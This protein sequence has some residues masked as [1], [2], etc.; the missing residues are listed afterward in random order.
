MSRIGDWRLEVSLRDS[1][2]I[3]FSGVV[4]NTSTSSTAVAVH[5]NN[6]AMKSN[7]DLYYRVSL[8]IFHFEVFTISTIQTSTQYVHTSINEVSLSIPNE[9]LTYAYRV[10][11][12]LL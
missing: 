3:I 12:R 9:N 6:Q 5:S 2:V 10:D 1:M 8:S 11:I 7:L 4:S